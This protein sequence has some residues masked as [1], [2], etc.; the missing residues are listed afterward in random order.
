MK[1]AISKDISRKST[2]TKR[3][4]ESEKSDRKKG[5]CPT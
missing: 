3:G 1:N 5:K 4:N 2:R